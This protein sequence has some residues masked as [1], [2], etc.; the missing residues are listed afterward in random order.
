MRFFFLFLFSLS[1]VNAWAE[2]YWWGLSEVSP[3]HYSSAD[4]ACAALFEVRAPSIL[5]AKDT[6]SIRR[7]S[8]TQA[9]CQL[10]YKRVDDPNAP[11]ADVNVLVFRF[12]TSCPP[13]TKWNSDTLQC[14]SE[15]K[16][17]ILSG[18]S[19][20]FSK[21]GTAPD[22]YMALAGK[23]AAAKQSGCF[24]GCLASTADQKCTTKTSGPYF[25]RGTAWFTGEACDTSG[26]PGV[27][28]SSS[29]EYPDPKQTE[30]TK[31]C[32][33]V[34]NPDGTQSCSSEKTKDTEGQ[35]CGTVS[36][37]GAKICVDKQPSKNGLQIDTTVKTEADPDGGTKTTKTDKAT[38]TECT[39]IKTCTSTTTTVTTVVNGKG[40]TT[41]TCTGANCPDK[42]TNPDGNGDGFGD[43]VSG[44]CGSGEGGDAGGLSLP[45]LDDV[46]GFGESTQEFVDKVSGSRIANAMGNVRAPGGSCPIFQGDAGFLGHLT[47]DGHCSVIAGNE[48]LIRLAAKTI[49]ALLACWILLG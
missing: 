48:N 44:D 27:D 17:K 24:D 34:T 29:S 46:P 5:F 18:T 6:Y 2:D 10:V 39:A 33:Y 13:G 1:S 42:T 37:T 7:D 32:T 35:V 20:A 23:T 47:I 4:S 36:A 8:D 11:K 12:G 40:N 49:W 25:C 38:T 43:C 19:R 21:S 14:A 28:N 15:D 45:K 31:P 9:L 41:S 3:Q 26:T 22:G 30:D 16:C